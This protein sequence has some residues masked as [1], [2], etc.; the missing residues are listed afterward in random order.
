MTNLRATVQPLLAET[1]GQAE[2]MLSS[3]LLNPG[4]TGADQRSPD[5]IMGGLSRQHVCPSDSSPRLT[6]TRK[7]AAQLEH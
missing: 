2:A 6:L 5:R 1:Q 3:G 7:A 4:L